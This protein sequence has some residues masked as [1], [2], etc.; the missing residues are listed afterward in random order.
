MRQ[1]TKTRVD[2]GEG[3]RTPPSA[4]AIFFLARCQNILRSPLSERLEQASYVCMYL[5]YTSE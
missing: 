2:R 3:A 4:L 1:R 5:V